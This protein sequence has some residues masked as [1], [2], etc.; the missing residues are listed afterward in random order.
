MQRLNMIC[1]ATATCILAGCNQPSVTLKPPA[2]QSSENTVRDWNDVA[3]KISAGMA[4]RG[5]LPVYSPSGEPVSPTP[6]P[7]MVRLQAPDSTFIREVPVN[8]KATSSKGRDRGP[9]T[10]RSDGREPGRQFRE[11]GTA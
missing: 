5:L 10:G 1:L 3:H 9:D 8:W 6:K 2:S 7:I 4:L 11:M